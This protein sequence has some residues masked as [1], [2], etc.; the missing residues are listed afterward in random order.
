[1]TR[2]ETAALSQL[3][4]DPEAAAHVGG[5][6]LRSLGLVPVD[7]DFA[8]TVAAGYVESVEEFGARIDRRRVAS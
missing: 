4:C 5:P 3:L 2:I 7:R 1:V 6:L 8:D